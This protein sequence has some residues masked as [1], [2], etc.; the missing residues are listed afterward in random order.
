M[1]WYAAHIILSFFFLVSY[2]VM[3]GGWWTVD[4]RVGVQLVDLGGS[5]FS[6]LLASELS[7]YTHWSRLFSY[8]SFAYGHSRVLVV[9]KSIHLCIKIRG[10]REVVGEGDIHLLF[11]TIF[12]YT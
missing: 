10:Q 3:K 9:D 6:V 12:F 8:L 1:S 11:T 7:L 5:Y 2:T 4:C